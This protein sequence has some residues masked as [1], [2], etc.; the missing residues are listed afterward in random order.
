VFSPGVERTSAGY[1]NTFERDD[2]L[3]WHFDRSEFGVN[4]VLQQPAS[5]GRFELHHNTRSAA[6]E[7][8][9]DTVERILNTPPGG[10]HPESVQP[11]VDTASDVR[12]GSLVVFSGRWS[13]HRVT[14][15]TDSLPRINVILTYEKEGPQ[16]AAAAAAAAGGGGGQP[17]NEYSLR[18]FFGR[19]LQDAEDAKSRRGSGHEHG[20][21]AGPG[22]EH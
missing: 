11:P 1:I 7:W 15:V 8:A 4:I 12:A 2:G 20:G 18:K 19:T 22:H 6:D 5:G 17:S 9:F 3:G 21:G 10:R 14:P 16:A 13:L